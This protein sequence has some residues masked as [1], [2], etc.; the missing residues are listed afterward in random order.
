MSLFDASV[1]QVVKDVSD[2]TLVAVPNRCSADYCKIFSLIERKTRP[3]HLPWKS[4][5]KYIPT[6]LTLN[7]VLIEPVD[8]KN[9]QSSSVLFQNYSST[10]SFHKAGKIGGKIAEE[11]DV[12]VSVNETMQVSLKL[13]N[14]MKQEVLWQKLYDAVNGKMV[15]TDH[16]LLKAIKSCKKRSLFLIGMVVTSGLSSEILDE[17]MNFGVESVQEALSGLLT[18]EVS[19]DLIT[20]LRKILKNKPT[21]AFKLNVVV[22][23]AIDTL[24]GEDVTCKIT[25]QHLQKLFSEDCS[26]DCFKFLVKAG[27]QIDKEKNKLVYPEKLDLLKS[28]YVL[29]DCLSEMSNVQI[30]TLT[31]CD[32]SHRNDIML[33]IQK[34]IQS[35]D[36]NKNNIEFSEVFADD[37]PVA[38]FLKSVGL[39]L[40]RSDSSVHVEYLPKCQSV[41]QLRSSLV[42]VHGMCAV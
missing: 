7:D 1:N 13:G 15:K 22:E 17:D 41:L 10:P 36:V 25:V 21:C 33:P 14:V 37:H 9:L 31:D 11:F 18:N 16:P 42:A 6:E 4:E 19:N 38:R 28:L 20:M 5:Y 8:V 23:N 27:F 35:T 29:L 30:Q 26:T 12:D 40:V 3:W 24:Q 34:V 32:I 2:K 39:N